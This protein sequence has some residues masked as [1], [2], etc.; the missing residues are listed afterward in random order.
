MFRGFLCLVVWLRVLRQMSRSNDRRFRSFEA[1]RK[2]ISS[3][4]GR[5]VDS[6]VFQWSPCSSGAAWQARRPV[7]TLVQSC[8]GQICGLALQRL[9]KAGFQLPVLHSLLQSIVWIWSWGQR[10]A[11]TLMAASL[12][13]PA[14]GSSL[15]GRARPDF[16]FRQWRQCCGRCCLFLGQCPLDLSRTS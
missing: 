7:L 10:Q 12:H 4:F 6:T 13:K 11:S 5:K 14:E 16:L 15:L 8:K 2:Q 9:C 1:T 3:W